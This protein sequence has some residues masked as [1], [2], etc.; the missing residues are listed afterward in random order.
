MTLGLWYI[1]RSELHT[2]IL[3]FKALLPIPKVESLIIFPIIMT[4]G[5][6]RGSRVFFGT[7]RLFIYAQRVLS[8]LYRKS[9]SEVKRIMGEIQWI[10]ALF[11]KKENYFF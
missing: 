1:D 11:Q 4:Q 7:A 3:D 8:A 10:A 2:K 5:R 9:I 6:K